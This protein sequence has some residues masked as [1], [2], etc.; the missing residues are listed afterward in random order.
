METTVKAIKRVSEVRAKRERLFYLNRV[1]PKKE[2]ETGLAIKQME[3]NIA[4]VAT[5]V[6][7]KAEKVKVAKAEASRKMEIDG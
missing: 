5:G 4:L 3:K 7:K 1:E 6:Q 2:A